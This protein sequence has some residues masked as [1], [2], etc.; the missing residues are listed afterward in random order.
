LLQ[1]IADISGGKYFFAPDGDVLETVYLTLALELRSLVITD[2]LTPGV[3]TECSQWPSGW[4]TVSSSGVTTLTFP[5]TDSLLI[6]GPTTFCFAA[7]VNLDPGYEGPIN[8]PGS[9]VCYQDAEG[10]PACQEFNNPPVAVGGRK[11]AGWVFY[12]VN[13]NGFRDIGET[14]VP[15]V[16]VQASTGLTTLTSSDGGYVLR[17]SSEPTI[18]VTIEV[19]SGYATTTQVPQVIPAVTGIYSVEFGIRTAIYLP[20]VSMEYP[21]PTII[22]GGFEDGWTGWGHGGGLAQTIASTNPYSDS[23]SALLGDS[24]YVCQGGVPIGS[25]WTEQIFFVPHTSDPRLSFWY[26]I[27]TQDLNPGLGDTFDS[28]DVRINGV[29]EFRD[30]KE[31]GSYGCAPQ[32]ERDLGW[33][34][35]VIDLGNYRGQ[36]ITIRFENRNSPDGWY[37]TWAFVDEVRFVP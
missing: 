17:T 29:L 8:L 31:H 3:Q 16:I 15:S 33:R 25:A 12:D 13:A 5:I 18:S 27:F 34:T 1:D 10:Q 26:N 30:A 24:S 22:N 36:H 20:I 37:N 21:L 35:G 2:I 4:C 19:P 23:F 32:V 7:T 28:F 11:I 14:G 9:G 6:S